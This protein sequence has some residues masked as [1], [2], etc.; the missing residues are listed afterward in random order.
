MNDPS[1]HAKHNIIHWSMCKC[2][3]V[4]NEKCSIRDPLFGKIA[5]CLLGHDESKV[6]TKTKAKVSFVQ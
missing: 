5:F 3:L 4:Q 6:H 1:P 2:E